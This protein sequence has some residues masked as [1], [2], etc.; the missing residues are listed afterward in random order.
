MRDRSLGRK[1]VKRS[2]RPEL[3]RIGITAQ[4]RS[5]NPVSSQNVHPEPVPRGHYFPSRIPSPCG[6]SFRPAGRIV[7]DDLDWR[8]RLLDRLLRRV[9]G[10][11]G[12]L[13]LVGLCGWHG[14]SISAAIFQAREHASGDIGVEGDAGKP[15]PVTF[16][17]AAIDAPR[18]AAGNWRTREMGLSE[19]IPERS[20]GHA[21]AD[22]SAGGRGTGNGRVRQAE[23]FRNLKFR[24]PF[25]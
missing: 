11:V 22:V 5:A 24:H 16:Q 10:V 17:N 4:S 25:G 18:I 12:I 1:L 19:P 6:N 9:A 8:F 13:F 14:A 2:R 7:F 3:V 23:V 15:R 20:G 21:V